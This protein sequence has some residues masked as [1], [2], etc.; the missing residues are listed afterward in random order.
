MEHRLSW[1]WGNDISTP[2][3]RRAALWHYNLIDHGF[4]RILWTNLY[5]IAPG[6]W[7]SNQPGPKRVQ[8]YADMGIRSILSLRGHSDFSFQILEEEA[9]ANAGMTFHLRHL[10][11]RA[12]VSREQVLAV[13]DLFD[14]IERPFLMHC[15]SGA[16]RAGLASVLYLIHCEGWDPERAARK[17]L[18][19]RFWH[20]RLT[21]TGILDH[22]MDAYIRAYRATGIPIRDWIAT[23]YD[24]VALTES[25]RRR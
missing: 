23:E 9:C 10:A 25:Y 22:M 19:M 2:A 16:D 15:K 18:S 12:L 7:R 6:V 11:A 8:R 14:T 13:I 1:S 5:E 20:S 17:H 3:A 21:K 4:V 24:P